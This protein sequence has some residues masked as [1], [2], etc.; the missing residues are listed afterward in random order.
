[1]AGL[2]PAIHDFFYSKDVD[3]RDKPGHDGDWGS[4]SV[5]YLVPGRVP[6]VQPFFAWGCFRV[7]CLRLPRH[8]SPDS[9]SSAFSI[10]SSLTT[11][12]RRG[13]RKIIV[14]AQAI[15]STRMAML[16]GNGVAKW[17]PR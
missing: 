1:M 14:E 16:S 10:N 13:M 7:F 11:T 12:S 3:A 2:D 17:P 5:P 8:N 9:S 15:D 6:P 4:R